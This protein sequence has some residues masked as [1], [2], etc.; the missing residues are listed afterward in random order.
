MKKFFF[1]IPVLFCCYASIYS[2][3][4]RRISQGRYTTI[5]GRTRPQQKR[6]RWS[7]QH[8]G[9]LT[10]NL[11]RPIP[12]QF[13]PIH[14]AAI[15]KSPI[16]ENMLLVDPNN[17]D[18][19]VK[20]THSLLYQTNPSEPVRVTNNKSMA[21]YALEPELLG[22]VMG[23]LEKGNLAQDRTKIV[24]LWQKKYQEKAGETKKLS[25]K[26]INEL[27]DLFIQGFQENKENLFSLLL[28]FLY[29]KAQPDNN[30]DMIHFLKGLNTYVPLGFAVDKSLYQSFENPNESTYSSKD[31]NQ[32][33]TRLFSIKNAAARINYA[34]E[35][36]PLAI[37]TLL[38]EKRKLSAYP[39]KT[40]FG[41]YSYQ[42][43]SAVS[44]CS[45]SAIRDLWNNLLYDKESQKFNI[46][47]LPSNLVINNIMKEFYQ[48]Y[49]T[50]D[51]INRYKSG[52]AFM[53]LISNIPGVSYAQGNY[54]LR[55][56]D[57]EKNII[58]LFNHFFGTK[59]SDLAELSSQL[60]DEKRT[61]SFTKDFSNPNTKKIIMLIDD[62]AKNE[63]RTITLCF[64]TRH[65]W[66][67]YADEEIEKNI[68]DAEVL[69]FKYGQHSAIKSLFYVHTRPVI[70]RSFLKENTLDNSM[71]YALPTQQDYQKINIIRDIL[72]YNKSSVL[73]YAYNLFKILPNES[74][75]ELIPEIL[76]S[77]SFQEKLRKNTR[78]NQEF[79][80]FI[81]NNLKEI[82]DRIIE[83]PDKQ[84]QLLEKLKKDEKEDLTNKLAKE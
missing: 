42:N 81:K 32:F 33:K 30:H 48:E 2:M 52:Q 80:I 17:S 75:I 44:N 61:I 40:I 8:L 11:T 4:M 7:P 15:A 50:I 20:I 6:L 83:D 53:N 31:Y 78:L 43:R 74:R 66:T 47:L 79:N 5:P 63:K 67:E 60:S 13:L 38:E 39:P 58:N 57:S 35:N 12:V 18:V 22:Y 14:G 24:D 49:Q 16:L 84:N 19:F 34:Q 55:S 54:E 77:I 26:K 3:L 29:L 76:N 51:S 69:S 65:S 46:S 68:L 70:A 41:S 56:Q 71:I 73:D 10:N 9:S 21:A 45:E 64:S 59:S 28:G 36:L 23:A 82:F 1:V 37:S 25:H 27:L 62:H 72:F